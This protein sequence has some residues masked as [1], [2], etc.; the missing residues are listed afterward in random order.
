M[1]RIYL[2]IFL[3]LSVL[4]IV[5]SFYF[6]QLY[7]TPNVAVDKKD[8][9]VFIPKGSS[10]QDVADSLQ[11]QG[12]VENLVGFMFISK[13]MKYDENVKPG[14]YRLQPDMTNVEAIRKL[15]S[16]DQDPVKV[17]FTASSGI[18]S[19]AWKLTKNLAI[20]EQEFLDYLMQ[21]SVIEQL[22]FT[23][24]TLP[25]MFI[26]NTYEM[27]YTSSPKTV[28]NRLKR[29]YDRFWN[30]SRKSKAEAMNYSPVEVS[31]LASIVFG[32]TKVNREMPTVAGLYLNRMNKGMRL[33][34]DPTVLFALG[35]TSVRR[36]L[37]KHLQINSPYN[38]YKRKG[39][40]PGPINIPPIAAIDAVLNP[41]EHDYLFMVAKETFDGSHYF[42][43]SYNQHLRNARK[44]QKALNKLKVLK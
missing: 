18:E 36:V 15:R 12:N 16:G 29:E 7:K 40:P 21:D 19:A 39:L 22:G 38:T 4:A 24:E 35:D 37:L 6:Y 3:V 20:T 42:T 32:E 11:E 34:S 2:I 28:V 1:K 41:D 9:Y 44:Y 30:D 25:S 13:L 5:F 43:A 17:T 10:I 33:E 26:P 8:A 31:T 27:Y 23:K 14:Y